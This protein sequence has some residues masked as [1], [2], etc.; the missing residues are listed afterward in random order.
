MRGDARRPYGSSGRV[1]G[2]RSRSD[3]G[4]GSNRSVGGSYAPGD[5]TAAPVALRRG[6]RDGTVLITSAGL[7]SASD[8]TA[9]ITGV[10]AVAI[11]VPRSQIIGTITAAATAAHAEISSVWMEIPLFFSIRLV[12]AAHPRAGHDVVGSVGPADPCFVAAVVVVAEQDQGCRLADRRALLGALGVEPPPDP[13]EAVGLELVGHRR[14]VGVA[15]ADRRVGR[16]LEQHV[17]DRAPQILVAGAPRRAHPAD[18]SLEQRVA[19][20]HVAVDEQRQHP[21]GVPGRVQRPHRQPTDRDLL[22]R[23]HLAGGAGYALV[24]VGEHG[25]V[26]PALED[27]AELGDVIVV[28]MGQQHVRDGQAELVGR[29]QQR[30]DRATGIDDERVAAR[31]S[32]DEIRVGKPVLAHRAFDDHGAEGTLRAV[33]LIHTCYRIGDIDRSVAFYDALRFEERSRAPIRDEAINGFMALPGNGDRLELTYNHGVDSY[34]LG[35]GYNHIALTVDDIEGTLQR[36]GEQ[37]IEPE[38]PPY[39]VR[40]G[41]SLIAF[42]RDPDGY[43]IELIEK[44]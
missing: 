44:S 18:R 19:G 12:L 23:L 31:L 20:E 29:L 32:R 10:I 40:E 22:V 37:G 15:R 41:G 27:L 9:T 11:S 26:G 42:V 30:R 6:R 8:T 34:E 13:D 38:K 24:G 25:G 14:R 16:Q 43:R 5:R 39:R 35:T 1:S 7:R 3:G 28:V 33:E 17:H 36:L 4:S 21:R 2:S